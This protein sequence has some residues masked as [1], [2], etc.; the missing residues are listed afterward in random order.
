LIFI[1]RP[2]DDPE[3][4]TPPAPPLRFNFE[5]ARLQRLTP[6]TREQDLEHLLR[7]VDSSETVGAFVNARLIGLDPVFPSREVFDFASRLYLAE[8]DGLGET[9]CD[10][11]SLDIVPLGHKKPLSIKDLV[12]LRKNEDGFEAVREAVVAWEAMLR[13]PVA[14]GA[15]PTLVLEAARRSSTGG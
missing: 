14:R 8:E 13:E 5:A 10:L 3:P 12:S 9:E 7:R 6:P 4:P 11:T 2:K 1:G 15:D